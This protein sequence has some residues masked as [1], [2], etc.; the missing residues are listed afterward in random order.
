MNIYSSF[1]NNM[2]LLS[3]LFIKKLM[4]FND[5]PLLMLLPLSLKS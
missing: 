3:I 1:F 5:T 2:F 4:L